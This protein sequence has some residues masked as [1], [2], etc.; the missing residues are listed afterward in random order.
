MFSVVC[1]K[2]YT[3]VIREKFRIGKTSLYES[4]LPTSRLDSQSQLP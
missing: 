2:L 3:D 1:L 4:N